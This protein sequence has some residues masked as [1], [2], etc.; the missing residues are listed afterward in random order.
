MPARSI[1]ADILIVGGGIQGVSLLHELSA[2]G[3]RRVL[4]A[5][6]TELGLGETLHSHGYLHRGYAMA[7][8][9]GE[10]D[11]LVRELI[12][13]AAW[14]HDRIRAPYAP[15]PP[16][17]YCVPGDVAPERRRLWH[18]LGLR[19]ETADTP[20]ALKGGEA[21]GADVRLFSI[22]DR[23]VS[24][25]AL[26]FELADSLQDRMIRAR[27]TSIELDDT[28]TRVVSCGLSSETGALSIRPRILLL[29]CG[30]E[31]QPL[32]RAAHTATGNRPLEAGCAAL[33]RI[34]YVPML[35]VRGVDLPGI[36]GIFETHAL[37]L[38]THPVEGNESMWIL[39]L[40]GGHETERGDFH[41]SRERRCG[42]SVVMETVSRLC[43]LV[44]EARRRRDE[45]LLFSFYFGGKTDH[46]DGGNGRHVTDCGV[47]NLRLAW[48]GVWSL[49]LPN[50]REIASGLKSSDRF[51]S[52]FDASRPPIDLEEAGVPAGVPVGE[53]LRLTA[54][55]TWLPWPEF[56]Q[57][58][59]GV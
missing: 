39:T 7:A 19:H 27:L 40:M 10:T 49:S 16:V 29:A 6:A 34:R 57:L 8:A 31:T 11:P 38:L 45:D 47:T 52:V 12:E 51:S 23:L 18:R 2:A 41:P 17:H 25:R 44:P 37:N 20:Q 33:N 46:P 48:P 36:S 5:S 24:L 50:A 30:R 58:H 59:G 21:D 13:A 32:L 15:G 22:D 56:R 55:Q 43:S 1:D 53:E 28:G 26:L 42:G 3:A 35:L 54:E 4:L 9:G 14:W